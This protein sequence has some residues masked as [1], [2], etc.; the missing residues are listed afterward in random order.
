MDGKSDLTQRA[1][2]RKPMERGSSMIVSRTSDICYD[3]I[4]QISETP[5]GCDQP[6][7]PNL[8]EIGPL[9]KL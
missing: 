7:T 1:H 4:L 9:D 8:K 3:L 6:R 2:N 5:S